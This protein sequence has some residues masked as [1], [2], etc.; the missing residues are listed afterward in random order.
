MAVD[1]QTRLQVAKQAS[2]ISGDELRRQFEGEWHK[3]DRDKGV[4]EADRVSREAIRIFLS[5]VYPREVIWGKQMGE[6]PASPS[7]WVVDSLN[8]AEN[9][10]TGD[11]HFATTVAW[12]ENG[13]PLVGVVSVPS[14]RCL[15]TAIKGG[16][17]FFQ[18]TRL[19]ARTT[20]RL[21]D[22]YVLTGFGHGAGRDRGF[23]AAMLIKDKVRQLKTREAPA[24]EICSVAAGIHDAFLHF[25]LQPWEWVAA[26][27]ILEEAGGKLTDIN[28]QPMKLK[29][30]AALA[31][32]GKLHAELTQLLG[33]HA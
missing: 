21:E 1:L 25:D 9:F 20:S 24:L 13:E 19:T 4:L 23:E 22:S 27:L 7:F 26:R 8:G 12:V 11:E 16:G 29:S 15:Y 31:S 18:D 6:A 17:A 28:N 14:K 30:R 33:G 3:G 10:A 5:Q 32:N 2:F